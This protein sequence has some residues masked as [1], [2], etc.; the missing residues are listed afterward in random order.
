MLSVFGGKI[1][2]FRKLAEEAEAM[3]SAKTWYGFYSN[4]KTFIP[5]T[6]W[7]GETHLTPDDIKSGG[8]FKGDS[9]A[10]QVKIL[11]GRSLEVRKKVAADVMKFLQEKSVAEKI[12]TRHDNS[13]DVIEM[14]RDVYQKTTVTS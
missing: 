3:S 5:W 6:S 7:Y 8:F 4:A 14:D 1:T 10:D 11:A 9:V 12:S 13:V 2:T